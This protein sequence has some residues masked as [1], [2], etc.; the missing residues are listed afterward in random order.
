MSISKIYRF[1]PALLDL[2]KKPYTFHDL[3]ADLFAGITVSLVVLPIAI[4]FS[5]ASIDQGILT[6]YSIPAIGIFTAMMAGLLISLFSGTMFQIAGPSATMIPISILILQKY[7]FSGL[8][9]ATFFAGII[10][11]TLGFLKLGVLMKYLPWPFISGFTTGIAISVVIDEIGNLL[12]IRTSEQ[13]PNSFLD[14]LDWFYQNRDHYTL[15]SIVI[16]ST[17]LIFIYLWRKK[18]LKQIP[19]SIVALLLVTVLVYCIPSHILG[20]VITIS[21]KYGASAIPNHLPT[22]HLPTITIGQIPSL[23]IASFAIVI[24]CSIESLLAAVITDRLTGKSHYR[25]TEL[26]AQGISNIVSPFFGGLPSTGL[27]IPTSLNVKSGARSPVAGI[28]Y[29]FTFLLI[30]LLLSEYISR[31]PMGVIAAILITVAISIGEWRD[32]RRLF[33]IPLSD[34]CILLTALILTVVF[35][36]IVALEASMLLAGMVFIRRI[37]EATEI[38]CITTHDFSNLPENERPKTAIPKGV[39]ICSIK[40]PLLFGVAEKL[41]EIFKEQNLTSTIFI[42]KLDLVSIMDATA[43]NMIEIISKKIYQSA[44]V[45][46]ISGANTFNKSLMERAKFIEFIGEKNFCVNL[47]E[48]LKRSYELIP[49]RVIS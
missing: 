37:T 3:T 47:E 22:F 40:G 14:K 43:L 4:G 6:P 21:S 48:S 7:G 23:F 20:S 11:A 28:I 38:S 29:A 18:G 24:G 41:E 36:V 13:E 15:S 12:G 10:L 44:G 42:L 45:L 2:F 31:I 39:I 9:V 25:N 8:L 32:L 5:V 33:Q 46:I 19:S 30:V 1:H 27:I 49:Q 17:T 16:A 26:I 35:D 34:R